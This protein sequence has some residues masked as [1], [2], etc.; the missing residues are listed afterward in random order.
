MLADV[1]AGRDAVRGAEFRVQTP[2][3]HRQSTAGVAQR[4]RGQRHPDVL[5]R[6]QHQV[7]PQG[8]PPPVT[9]V[10]QSLLL[11]PDN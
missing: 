7:H 10:R 6:R 5:L 1:C 3:A 11:Q 8:H 2:G 9:R 4:H